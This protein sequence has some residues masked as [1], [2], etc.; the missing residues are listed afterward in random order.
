VFPLPV[1]VTIMDAGGNPIGGIPVVFTAPA[2]GASGSYSGN[3][4]VATD[5]QGVATAPAFTANGITGSYTLTATAGALSAMFSMTNAP[6]A[7]VPA[8]FNADGH[9]DIIWQDPVSGASQVWLLNGMPDITLVG[10]VPV[11]LGNAWRIVA[12]A[13]FNGDGYPDVVWQD[14][15]SGGAQVWFLGPGL[16]FLGA[17]TVASSNPWRIV[18]AA[19]FN[20][21][22]YPDLVWQDPDSGH[23]QIW[24]LGGPQGVTL[25]SAADLTLSNPWHVVGAGDFNGDG[26]PDL[27]WQDP[28]SGTVQ[29][30][31]LGG[32]QGNVLAGAVNLTGANPWR[33]ASVADYDGDGHPDVV[34]QDPVSGSSQVWFLNG[35]NLTGATLLSGPNAWRIAAPR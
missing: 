6:A 23:V 22:G 9:T 29:L 26:Q 2:T 8:D 28:I 21:D 7:G 25:A 19:D 16:T 12:V 4:T 33:I 5:A 3:T 10:A 30:W 17:A 1:A 20:R 13:D 15:V 27:L 18:A 31:Y 11:S 14:P 32:I 34:W 24:Y 35:V